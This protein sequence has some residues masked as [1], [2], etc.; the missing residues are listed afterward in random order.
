MKHAIRN[1]NG[2]KH[3][4]TVISED[5][6]TGLSTLSS[7]L[8]PFLSFLREVEASCSRGDSLNYGEIVQNLKSTWK[9]CG[10]KSLFPME[11]IFKTIR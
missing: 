9:N 5:L 2:N 7:S 11:R 8:L 1:R 3:C 4:K 10:K 6:L